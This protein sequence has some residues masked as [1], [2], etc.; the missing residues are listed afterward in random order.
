MI[1]PVGPDHRDGHTVITFQ[2]FLCHWVW[3]WNRAHA[4][5]DNFSFWVFFSTYM[6]FTVSNSLCSSLV[7]NGQKERQWVYPGSGRFGNSAFV[8]GNRQ[9][10]SDPPISYFSPSLSCSPSHRWDR[11]HL[12]YPN[13]QIVRTSP[14][15][16]GTYT[17]KPALRN[18]QLRSKDS[19][20]VSRWRGN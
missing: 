19:N 6:N 7:L 18:Q 16:D 5:G 8:H 15:R 20:T 12:S 9:T 3:K 17:L 1:D 2:W 4:A 14:W 10:A 13:H 11:K